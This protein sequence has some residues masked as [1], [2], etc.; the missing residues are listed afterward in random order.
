MRIK[1]KIIES[2][3]Y[4][5]GTVS[6]LIVLFIVFFLFKEGSGVF[7][8]KP[9]EEG[10]TLAVNKFNLVEKLDASQIKKIFEGEISNWNELGGTYDSIYTFTLSD[11]ETKF[12][13]EQLGENFEFLN[14]RIAEYIENNTGVIAYLPRKYVDSTITTIDISNIEFKDIALGK[15]WYPTSTPSPQIG[16]LP[17]IWGS[18]LVS[19]GAIMFAFPLGLIIAIYLSE[20]A[21][22][23][24]KN[25]LKTIIE[26]LSGIPSVVY[27]FFGLIVIVPLVKNTFQLDMGESMLAGS[28]ILSLIA[29]PTIISL[30]AD[31]I[32]SAPRELKDA[33]LALGATQL[34]TIFGITLPYARSGI[35]SA[36]ILGV[37]R[38]FGETMAVLMVTGNS[39]IFPESIFQPVRTITATIASE[40]GEAS[41]GGIHYETLFV[42]GAILFCFTF[43]IN[44]LASFIA[45]RF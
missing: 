35:L 43:I 19:I 6:A 33:S 24:E 31:S 45:N 21:H 26:L 7:N 44:L 1:E 40:L 18:I 15:E 16:A 37:G 4:A 27:G 17:I 8:K 36:T 11:V 25:I 5:C 23:F 22:P 30:S 29:L 13:A 38:A 41:T 32:A 2:I 28:I 12:T 42:L 14:Q 9:I 39:A 10:Y 34:Q 20:I 3:I